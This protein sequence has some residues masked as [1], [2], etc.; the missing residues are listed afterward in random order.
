[1]KGKKQPI[2]LSKKRDGEKHLYTDQELVH[3]IQEAIRK[4]DSISEA[5]KYVAVKAK[6][7]RVVL[8]GTVPSEPEKMTS[9]I[10]QLPSRGLAKS[11]INYKYW[12]RERSPNFEEKIYEHTHDDQYI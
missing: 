12:K 3:E 2:I 10:R 8:T 6:N 1:M 9:E 11:P 4:E 7:G 5:A